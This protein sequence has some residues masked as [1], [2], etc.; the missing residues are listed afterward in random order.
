MT[1]VIKRMGMALM[2]CGLAN[3]L[4]TC[5]ASAATM[6][7]FQTL[8]DP[9]ATGGTFAIGINDAGTVVGTAIGEDLGGIVGFLF[10]GS[11]PTTFTAPGSTTT[12]ANG[13]NDAGAIV[14]REQAAGNHGFL[15]VGSTYTTIDDPNG[16]GTS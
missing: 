13:I 12:F 14:G 2:A 3:A 10:S 4:S 15:K 1:P 6:Y 7:T 9:N 5:P 11:T 16:F 8:D